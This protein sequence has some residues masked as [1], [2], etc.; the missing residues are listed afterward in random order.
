MNYIEI[1]AKALKGKIEKDE[2]PDLSI[3]DWWFIYYCLTVL[4][5]IVSSYKENKGDAPEYFEEDVA[6]ALERIERF[7]GHEI[8]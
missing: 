7:T 6:D 3:K 4:I 1:M 8:L 5:S 2:K